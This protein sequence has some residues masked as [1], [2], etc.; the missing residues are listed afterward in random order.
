M[1][2]LSGGGGDV[3]S[4]RFDPV[5]SVQLRLLAGP[6][7]GQ[8]IRVILDAQELSPALVRG[9][10]RWQHPEA[11]ERELPLLLLQEIERPSHRW[12]RP[13]PV[14][15]HL[16]HCGVHRCASIDAFA[17]TVCGVTRTI[18][19]VNIVVDP[20]NEHIRITDLHTG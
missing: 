7:P 11:T 6:T 5:D 14:H 19:D 13:W 1:D 3:A 4:R 9:R 16:A 20:S 10:L 8:H 15:R 2:E 18:Y 17:G 12:C